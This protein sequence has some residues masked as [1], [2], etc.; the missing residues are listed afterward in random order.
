MRLIEQKAE[1]SQNSGSKIS[2]LFT[3]IKIFFLSNRIQF[4]RSSLLLCNLS[5]A[6]SMNLLLMRASR[7]QFSQFMAHHR[8]QN[9]KRHVLLPI[10]NSDSMPYHIRHDS[11]TP[12]PCLNQLFLRNLIQILNF[13][14]QVIGD[15]RYP[16][17]G[18]AAAEAEDEVECGFL[19]NIVVG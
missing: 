18:S 7:F 6:L 11:R 15:E 2:N 5:L 14:H 8:L 19:L 17:A 13:L 4:S 10:V 16:P 1:T 3:Q 12:G 9:T